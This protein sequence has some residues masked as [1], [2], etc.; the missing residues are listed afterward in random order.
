MS[1]VLTH[2]K[3]HVCVV[4]ADGL[5]A[6]LNTGVEVYAPFAAKLEEIG[7]K[8]FARDV[9]SS[10]KNLKRIIEKA[11][12]VYGKH[13]NKMLDLVCVYACCIYVYM[14]VAPN[15]R[16]STVATIS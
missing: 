9:H 12:R 2:S 8:L 13:F 14:L 3:C 10:C 15:L 7:E 1:L 5:V 6:L 16:T 11:H 4:C